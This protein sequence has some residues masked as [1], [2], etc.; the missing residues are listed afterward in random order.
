[1][2]CLFLTLAEVVLVALGCLVGCVLLDQ[3]RVWGAL[4]SDVFLYVQCWNV[5]NVVLLWCR[6]VS[7]L[8]CNLG[9]LATIL[10]SSSVGGG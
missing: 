3:R 2:S 10:V 9:S 4:P 1:M 8:P 6:L 5:G 7:L